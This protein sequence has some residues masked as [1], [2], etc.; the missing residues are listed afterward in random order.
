MRSTIHFPYAREVTEDLIQAVATEINGTRATFPFLAEPR[1]GATLPRRRPRRRRWTPSSSARN[2]NPL[3]ATLS[4]GRSECSA[5]RTHQRRTTEER[6]RGARRRHGGVEAPV[7]NC[8]S[9]AGDP[10]QR[11]VPTC[12]AGACGAVAYS[13]RPIVRLRPDSTTAA[14]RL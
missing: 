9:P 10:C 5:G 7:R 13:S 2:P 1:G 4:Q 14:L 6:T 8:L 3:G 11:M 12:V